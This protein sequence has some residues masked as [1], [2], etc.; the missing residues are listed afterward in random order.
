MLGFADLLRP[1]PVVRLC[2]QQAELA[3]QSAAVAISAEK[4]PE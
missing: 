4:E 2:K 1:L 3:R